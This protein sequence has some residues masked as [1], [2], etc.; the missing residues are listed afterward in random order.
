MYL[1]VQLPPLLVT[2][3]SMPCGEESLYE[4]HMAAC[5]IHLGHGSPE[6]SSEDNTRQDTEAQNTFN[7]YVAWEVKLKKNPRVESDI[8]LGISGSIEDFT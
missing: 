7:R 8:E 6:T 4:S 1:F 5:Y 3:K 2:Y